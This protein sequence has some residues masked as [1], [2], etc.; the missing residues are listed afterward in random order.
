ML[1]SWA[2]GLHSLGLFG[3]EVVEICG[4]RGLCLCFESIID[5]LSVGFG[6][7]VVIVGPVLVVQEGSEILLHF[8]LILP[9]LEGGNGIDFIERHNCVC[10]CL[11]DSLLYKFIVLPCSCGIYLSD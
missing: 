5:V 2:Y 10:S 4:I 7:F 6:L 1:G 9:L 11:V 3:L 8:D